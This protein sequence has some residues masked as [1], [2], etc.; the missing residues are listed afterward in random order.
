MNGVIQ[1]AL[2]I[3]TQV[4][5]ASKQNAS[6]SWDIYLQ[7]SRINSSVIMLFQP[8]HEANDRKAQTQVSHYPHEILCTKTQ[9]RLCLFCR[10][11]NI[12]LDHQKILS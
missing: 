4:K 10:K 5:H 1:L 8:E 9:W 11:I 3:K 2:E 7:S 12:V 6:C